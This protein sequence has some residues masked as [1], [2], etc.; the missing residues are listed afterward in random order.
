MVRQSPIAST[1][2]GVPDGVLRVRSGYRPL[3]APDRTAIILQVPLGTPA[4]SIADGEIVARLWNDPLVG[5]AVRINH[6]VDSEGNRW[7]SDYLFLIETDARQ[8]STVSAGAI[9]GYS[10][11]TPIPDQTGRINRSGMGFVLRRNGRTVD[12]IPALNW[13]PF[14]LHVPDISGWTCYFRPDRTDRPRTV[15]EW[16]RALLDAG[17]HIGNSGPAGDG[18][19][20][21]WSELDQFVLE[22]FQ[23]ANGLRTGR[24]DRA[25]AD[26][27][28]AVAAGSDRMAA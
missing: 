26:L 18:V 25:T 20:G 13:R 14:E 15:T 8:W 22:G 12:P 1:F 6:G 7:M 5:H 11:R 19:D 17:L 23:E 2:S 28:V 27:L 4:V 24:R 9:V 3:E 21:L 10:G 16:E